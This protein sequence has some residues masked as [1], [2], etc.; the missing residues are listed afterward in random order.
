[1]TPRR[2][3]VTGGFGFIGGHL[4]ERL[5]RRGDDVVVV[6][7]APAP[8]DLRD[9]RAAVRHVPCDVRDAEALRLVDVTGVD[10]VYHLSSLVGVDRYLSDP[11]DVVDTSVLGTRNVL[12]LARRARAKLVLASTS[13]VYGKNPVAPWAEDADRVLGSTAADR[14][15]YSSSKAVAE[16][17]A[18]AYAHRFGLRLSIVRYFNVYGPRQRPAY[19]ISRTLHRLLRGERPLLYDGG[20]QT[21]CFTYVDDAVEATLLTG[22]SGAADGEVLNIGSD[23]EWTMAEAVDLVRSAVGS[24]AEPVVLR[25]RSAFGEA[26]EDIPRRVPDV[27]KA[28]RILGWRWGVPLGA[29]VARTVAWAHRSPWWA[30]AEPPGG[31]PGG[32]AETNRATGRTDGHVR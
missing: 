9:D 14:W 11:L 4:V 27:S 32:N 26:Y 20:E 25:T 19:V 3:L 12:D 13:E 17:L 6:D 15:S 22:G 18:L 16:H 24:D 10:E 30:A 28:R 5:L 8:P 1:M 23:Q 7:P 31:C 29:G 21:R 2:S